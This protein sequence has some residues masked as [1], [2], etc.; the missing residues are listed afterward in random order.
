MPFST[1]GLSPAVTSPLEKMQSVYAEMSRM[2]R[3]VGG[4][5]D[6]WA[7]KLGTISYEVICALGPRVERRYS[8]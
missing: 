8:S 3:T 1:L 7:A 4:T 2:A 5:P 6:E